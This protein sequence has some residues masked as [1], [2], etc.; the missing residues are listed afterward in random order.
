MRQETLNIALMDAIAMHNVAEVKKFIDMGADVNY[1]APLDESMDQLVYQPTTP[2]KLVMF[3]ISDAMLDDD[4]LKEFMEIAKLLVNY[5]ADP[6]PAMA[7]AE[8]R[9]GKFD[10]KA[11]GSLFMAVWR[12]VAKAV[13][14]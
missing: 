12:I 4:G 7:L 1:D 10:P 11:E 8:Q 5:G 6:K 9:Y 2:L 3:C 13:N 14:N